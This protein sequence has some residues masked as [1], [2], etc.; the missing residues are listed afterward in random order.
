MKKFKLNRVKMKKEIISWKKRINY[1][2]S[3]YE[4]LSFK[5]VFTKNQMKIILAL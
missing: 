3:H 2:L 5:S 4:N 1:F